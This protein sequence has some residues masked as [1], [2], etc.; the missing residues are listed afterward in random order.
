MKRYLLFLL[1]I[2]TYSSLYAQ[3]TFSALEG[4]SGGYINK[5]KANSTGVLFALT[6]DRIYKSADG[7]TSWT[8]LTNFPTNAGPIDLYIDGS[9]KLYVLNKDGVATSTDAGVSWIQI[10]AVS[11]FQFPQKLL[12]NESTGTLFMKGYTGTLYGLLK[13]TDEGLNWTASY[14]STHFTIKAGA[15]YVAPNGGAE[16]IAKN[17]TDGNPLS[18]SAVNTGLPA[19]TP[20]SIDV[21]KTSGNIYAT[22]YGS[23][24]YFTANNGT[25]WS[26]IASNPAT[27]NYSNSSGDWRLFMSDNTNQWFIAYFED[28]F[29]FN[30]R[31]RLYVNS[32]ANGTWT[33]L[34]NLNAFNQINTIYS[35]S[36][37]ILSGFYGTGI[38][39]STNGGTSWTG[40]DKGINQAQNSGL[41]VTNNSAILSA[42]GSNWVSRSFDNNFDPT[43]PIWTRELTAGA[44]TTFAKLSTGNILA[45][46][47]QTYES[48]N[49]NNGQSFTL[50][51]TTP[52]TNTLTK[53]Y[54][55]ADNEI[56]A[57]GSSTCCP[58][59]NNIY[60][61][62]NQ[63]VN[64]N[65]LAV[66][67][68][69]VN[70]EI[71]YV[72]TTTNGDLYIGLVD[73]GSS[74]KLYRVPDGSLA[75]T[76]IT[77]PG[78]TQYYAIKAIGTKIY[79][80]GF[81]S[82]QGTRV[83]VSTGFPFSWSH[84]ASSVYD[85]FFVPYEG[86]FFGV[87]G[88][89]VYLSNDEGDTWQNILTLQSGQTLTGVELDGSFRAFLSI[90]R[91]PFQKSSGGVVLPNTF[92][93]GLFISTNS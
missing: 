88:N 26:A 65:I 27:I 55:H 62:T 38:L 63:G 29:S 77:I 54:R 35:F 58:T 42:Y 2:G 1:L 48:T 47:S 19:A 51:G 40:G 52:G 75:A 53:A 37:T 39:K 89:D 22:F 93:V 17:S 73:N 72:S 15:I 11:G 7:S 57:I 43:F 66:T 9:D 33:E 87:N 24:T 44:M 69:P 86:V 91:G 12:K 83:A 81:V 90:N 16:R 50:K 3:I 13:S 70:R 79:A 25:S 31:V 36:S 80:L 21:N 59:V 64:W 4:P 46:G 78:F 6:N 67:G 82:A 8:Q 32:A 5:I 60:L 84:K 56:Y 28:K 68:L 34:T 18:W 71:T 76:Q 10:N 45:I 92:A 20:V 30:A 49:A 61:T 74:T 14:S 41:A 85:S 23:G